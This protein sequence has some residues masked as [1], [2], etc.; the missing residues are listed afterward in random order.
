MDQFLKSKFSFSGLGLSSNIIKRSSSIEYFRQT[1]IFCLFCNDAFY[2]INI[3][4]DLIQNVY[5][6]VVLLSRSV[7]SFGHRLCALCDTHFLFVEILPRSKLLFFL[8]FH[9]LSNVLY[10]LS[11]FIQ[12]F[13]G[14]Q[15]RLTH[16]S[17]AC[18]FYL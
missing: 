16:L 5:A 17:R 2:L 6:N 10:L 15:L 12:V 18:R 4:R 8:G 3:K 14:V 13:L 7:F 9:F 1:P 11:Q